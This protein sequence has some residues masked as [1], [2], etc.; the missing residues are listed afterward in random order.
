MSIPS[1]TPEQR[2]AFRQKALAMAHQIARAFEGDQEVFVVLEA[3]MLAHR[4]VASTLPPDMVG[5]VAME[6]AGY[7]GE[8]MQADAK[9]ISLRFSGTPSIPMSPMH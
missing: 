4:Y 9:R 6:M 2:A 7:A 5:T 1:P 3:L 8:L